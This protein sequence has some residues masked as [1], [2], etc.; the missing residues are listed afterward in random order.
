MSHASG[1]IGSE[2]AIIDIRVGVPI[3]RERMLRRHSMPVPD[4][5]AIK[6][7]LDTGAHRSGIDV[8]VFPT[9]ELEGAVDVESVRTSSS[10]GE[11][12]A[13][14]TPPGFRP[15]CCNG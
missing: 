5:I 14:T 8:A 1:K 2:G 11:D 12:S 13:A 15:R 6:A 4:P 7:V 10:F 9:L 3:A